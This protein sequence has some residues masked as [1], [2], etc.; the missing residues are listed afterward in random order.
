[1]KRILIDLDVLTIAL[2]KGDNKKIAVEF[3]S[4]VKNEEFY[5]ITP[6]TLLE[7]LL[8]WKNTALRDKIKEFY[9]EYS[10]DILTERK[11]YASFDKISNI[12]GVAEEIM[13]IGVKD[14]DAL[15]VIICSIFDIDYLV[16]FNRRHL[17]NNKEK[18]NE[19]LKKNGLKTIKIV[20]PNEI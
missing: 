4:K 10:E 17:K 3:L 19:V 11:V 18:I 20:E 6:F 15:L 5:I 7:L 13:N 14:E 1:M 9:L 8:E 16:T 12:F 2:W